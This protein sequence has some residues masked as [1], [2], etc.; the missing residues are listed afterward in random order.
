MKHLLL[1]TIAAVVLVG[2]GES[3]QTTPTPEANPVEPVAEV[4]K[5]EPAHFTLWQL[6]SQT[7]SQMMSYVMSTRGGK[8]MVV[9]GGNRGD[10]PQLRKF[11]KPLGNRVHAWFLSHPHPDHV[12]ALTAILQEQGSIDIDVI[13]ASLLDEE[14][15]AK[16]EPK[17]PTHLESVRAFRRA[18]KKSDIKLMEPLV[19]QEIRVDGN[20]IE[21]LGI[22]NPEITSNAINNSSLVLKVSDSNKSVLFTGDLGVEGGGKLLESPLRDRLRADYVQMSHHGQRGVDLDFYR[23]VSP[24]ACLW[25]TPRWLWENDSGDGLDSGPWETLTVRKWM[26][27]LGVQTHYVSAFGLQRIE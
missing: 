19:G 5:A 26:Q 23:A 7:S 14:W 3:Q 11:L 24:T 13:Y 12:D 15:V 20:L 21:I 16:H 8:V 27:E 18:V 17:P 22:K 9:D 25:P 10:A 6:P 2:C 4:I 1:T